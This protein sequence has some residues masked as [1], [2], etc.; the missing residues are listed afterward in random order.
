MWCAFQG[1]IR[2]IFSG[3]KRGP[4]RPSVGTGTTR[5]RFEFGGCGLRFGVEGLGF[6]GIFDVHFQGLRSRVWSTGFRVKG[7]GCR[8]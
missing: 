8:I 4:C 6:K 7:K 3:Y 5:P 1:A 2:Y